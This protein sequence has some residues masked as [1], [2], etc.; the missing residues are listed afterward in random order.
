VR[1][2]A[3]ELGVNLALVKASGPKNRILQ[4][5]VQAFVKGELAKPRTETMGGGLSTLPMPVIDFSQFGD[6]ETKPLITHQKTFGRQPTPQ[7]G[8]CATRHAV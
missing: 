6:I 2:F 5:D 1:K 7:L 4:T 3:R 8:D